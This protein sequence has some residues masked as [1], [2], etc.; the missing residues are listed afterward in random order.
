[1]SIIKFVDLHFKGGGSDKVYHAAIAAEGEGFLVNFAYGR[2]GNALSFGSKTQAPVSLEKA[3]KIYDKLVSEKTSK[4]YI[5]SPGISGNVF[6][7]DSRSSEDVSITSSIPIMKDRQSSGV[8]PQLLNT[9]D[10]SELDY[11]INSP[12]WGAQEK[13][14]GDRRLILF[15]DGIARGIN[16][17]GFFV[18]L[19]PAIE[20]AVRQI[21]VPLLIDGEAIGETL[22]AFNLLEYNGEDL[23]G[24]PYF[25]SYRKL[26]QALAP[27]TFTGLKTVP[28]ALTSKEKRE[29]LDKI[30]RQNGEGVVFK[31]LSSSYCPGRPNSGGDQIKFKFW[32]SASCIVTAINDKRSVSL[33]LYD[34]EGGIVDVGNVTIPANHTIPTH[35]DIVEVRY[36]YAYKGGSLY[37]PV[38]I[39][40]RT[41][42][43]LAED[44]II[45]QLKYKPE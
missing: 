31:R 41:D 7:T 43:L 4:G 36:L 16:R 25:S 13:Y 42:D 17:K 19:M 37:Q 1:M 8:L 2:H 23:R 30:K 24:V 15:K 40:K 28:L 9:C 5:P 27:Y 26:Q 14:D 44:C 22:Y 18:P 29:L 35:G 12:E 33:G 10:E 39:G 3:R 45:T 20:D 6:G 34:S 11:F 38:Y 21:G 32:E